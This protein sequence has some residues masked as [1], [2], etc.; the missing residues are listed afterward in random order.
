[1][2]VQDSREKETKG[3]VGVWQVKEIARQDGSGPIAG[4]PLPSIF[5]FTPRHYSMVWVFGAEPQGSFAERWNPTDAEKIRRFDSLVVNSGTYEIDGNTLIAHPV[6]A[7]IPD[8]MGG[9]LICEYHIE[10]DTMRLKFVDEYSFDG[11][12][13]PW[14]KSG[15]LIL[16]LV[17]IDS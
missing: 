13:A 14:V 1:M 15:G 9:K 16:T 6:I 3:V 10:K 12:Q 7:R 11:V 17:R 4:E 5:I 2:K 8:F